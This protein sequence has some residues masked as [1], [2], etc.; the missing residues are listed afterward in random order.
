MKWSFSY[1]VSV[2][3]IYFSYQNPVA[4][5]R[6]RP[7]TG[8]NFSEENNL[9]SQPWRTLGSDAWSEEVDL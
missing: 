8:L 7:V 1:E 4:P 3:Q 2:I 5:T 6:S 9:L